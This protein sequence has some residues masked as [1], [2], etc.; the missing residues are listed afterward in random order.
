[1]ANVFFGR[2]NAMYLLYL[3]D[4]GSPNNR[5]EGHFV[6]GGFI[7]PEDKL[8][9]VNKSLN[10]LESE[11]QLNHPGIIEFH[12]SD[13]SGGR[14]EPW[15]KIAIKQ[16]RFEIIKSVLRVAADIRNS[17]T[18]LAC[19]VEKGYY[20]GQDPV[21]IAFEDICN[22]FHLYLSRKH[23]LDNEKANGMIILDESSY[24]EP[25]QSLVKQFQTTGNK[26]KRTLDNI[27]EVPMFVDSKISRSIQLADHI[28]YSIFRRYECADLTYYNI[29][30]GVFDA[31]D[32]KIHGICHKTF[33]QSC[34]CTHCAQ[35]KILLK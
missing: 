6:L 16:D 4:S 13:I 22:R 3:D 23:S 1:M 28:A 19:A 15:K 32:G 33:N 29:I 30:E 9:W 18:V 10:A 31:E 26:W 12:A 11:L 14:T 34:T 21:E 2:R 35:R 20:P 25:L 27:L 7:I 17:I 24:K 5:K 8:Y